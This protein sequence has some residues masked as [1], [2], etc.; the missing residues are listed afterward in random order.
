VATLT[1]AELT[2]PATRFGLLDR[3]QGRA[4]ADN[5]HQLIERGDDRFMVVRSL[6]KQ[7]CTE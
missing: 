4:V 3:E 5:L 1:V 7:L 2:P 6:F